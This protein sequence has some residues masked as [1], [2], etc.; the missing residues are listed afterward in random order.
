MKRHTLTLLFGALGMLL[1][2]GLVRV[3]YAHLLGLRHAPGTVD[4]DGSYAGC[5]TCDRATSLL[6]PVFI[7]D[8]KRR[9]QAAQAAEVTS[10]SE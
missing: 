3:P 6:A 4:A 9:A 1:A 7:E 10:A 5:L 8:A 2:L